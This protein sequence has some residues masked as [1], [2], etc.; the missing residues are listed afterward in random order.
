MPSSWGSSWGLSW[1][2][3]W[4]ATVSAPGVQEY[5]S[6]GKD[7]CMRCGFIRG[8]SKLRKEWT[9]LLVCRDT[10]WEPR[11][12]QEFMRGKT[13]HQGV[14]WARPEP[15]PVYVLSSILLR[16]DGSLY[17]REASVSDHISDSIARET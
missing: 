6:P 5:V 2:A 10:C 7:R 13:D 15:S 11:H 14:P 3:S 16:E 4:G 12:P 17:L 9:G 8:K 1:G